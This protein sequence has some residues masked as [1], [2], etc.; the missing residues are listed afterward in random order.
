M[1]DLGRFWPPFKFTLNCM[2]SLAYHLSKWAQK[3][4]L[5]FVFMNLQNNL[6]SDMPLLF[7]YLKKTARKVCVE[8][9]PFMK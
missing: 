2:F 4:T 6:I 3:E 1:Y 9:F 5:C 8:D 7:Q